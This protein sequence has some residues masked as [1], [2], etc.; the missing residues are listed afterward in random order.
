MLL[1]KYLLPSVKIIEACRSRTDD[2]HEPRIT[3][4]AFNRRAGLSLQT[5]TKMKKE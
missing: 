3:A 2:I 5:D 1:T 4:G